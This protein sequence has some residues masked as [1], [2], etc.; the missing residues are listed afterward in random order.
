MS[1]VQAD[2]KGDKKKKGGSKKK[3]EWKDNLPDL[4][5][6]TDNIEHVHGYDKIKELTKGTQ[7]PSFTFIYH[8]QCPFCSKKGQPLM[9]A[10]LKKFFAKDAEL[11]E[12][13]DFYGLNISDVKNREKPSKGKKKGTV[14]KEVGL[15]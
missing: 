6:T 3:K 4:L 8:P 1:T 15:Y 5:A 9:K 11:A 14:Y 7:K 12:Q 10:F 2:D 13:V